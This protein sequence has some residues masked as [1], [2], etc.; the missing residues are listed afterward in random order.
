MTLRLWGRLRTL[1][2]RGA[3][4]RL[5]PPAALPQV[6]FHQLI[7]LIAPKSSDGGKPPAGEFVGDTMKIYML[8]L[9]I[10]A[11]AAM[12]HLNFERKSAERKA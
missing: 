1:S 12:S 6:T 3:M 11:I 7:A 8:M 9:L 5:R 2:Q 4:S 10:S